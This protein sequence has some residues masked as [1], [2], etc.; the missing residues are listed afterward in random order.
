MDDYTLVAKSPKSPFKPQVCAQ[1]TTPDLTH[2]WTYDKYDCVSM[3]DIGT[4]G[5]THSWN[6][7]QLR[8]RLNC[9]HWHARLDTFLKLMTTTVASQLPAL[10]HPAWHIFDIKY[11][12]VSMA[13]LA[14]PAWH[15]P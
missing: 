3:A 2:S 6:L 10:A 15:I 5:L 7:W 9:R 11:D 4:P 1:I 12:C 14:H 13:E 8:L